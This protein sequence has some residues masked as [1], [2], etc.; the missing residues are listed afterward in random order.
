[1]RDRLLKDVIPFELKA[2]L[3]SL[4]G[5]ITVT[6]DDHYGHATLSKDQRTFN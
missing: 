6:L 2:F 3:S 1:M 4:P 5:L